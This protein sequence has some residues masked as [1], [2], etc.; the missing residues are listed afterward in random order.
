MLQIRGRRNEAIT[1]DSIRQQSTTKSG[2]GD[3][4]DD[5]IMVLASIELMCRHST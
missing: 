1:A 3:G 4:R 5:G 2:C